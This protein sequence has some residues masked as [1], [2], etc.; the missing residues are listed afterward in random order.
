MNWYI[1][2]HERLT[3]PREYQDYLTKL[4]GRNRFGDPN[5]IIEWGQTATEIVQGVDANGR[6]G[7][8]TIL[9]HGGIA[10]WF[11]GVWY[12]PECFGTEEVWYALSWDWES[13]CPTLGEYPFRGLYMPAPFN[14]YVKKMTGG[15]SYFNS[16]GEV[17]EE[18]AHLE[19]DAMPMNYHILDLLIPNLMKSQEEAFEKKK[20]ALENRMQAEKLAAAKQA[21][22]AYLDAAPAFGGADFS[23]ASNREA[24][25]QR[26]A[27]KQAGMKISR[28]EIVRKLG[29]GHRQTR[30]VIK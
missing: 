20:I 21:M 9:K 8:H 6:R 16:K 28:N 14:L 13:D 19:I 11:I 25:L 15:G 5:F 2:G 17:V 4:G 26:I 10:A 1:K 18:P 23:G 22:D 3:V 27:E 30:K 7:Q 12:P 24:W 29:P